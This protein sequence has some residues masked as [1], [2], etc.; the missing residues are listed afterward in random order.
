LKERGRKKREREKDRTII[1]GVRE[2]ITKRTA[3]ITR[4]FER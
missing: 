4:F 2:G 1:E 3:E